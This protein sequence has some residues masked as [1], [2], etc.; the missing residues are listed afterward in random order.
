V[1]DLVRRRPIRYGGTDRSEPSMDESFT[2]L[3]AKK[4]AGIRVAV[5]DM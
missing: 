3:A 5:M 1:S 4:S 2:W